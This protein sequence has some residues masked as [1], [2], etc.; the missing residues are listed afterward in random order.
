[1]LVGSPRSIFGVNLIQDVNTNTNNVQCHWLE[2]RI[3]SVIEEAGVHDGLTVMFHIGRF[4]GAS[5][6]QRMWSAIC[7]ADFLSRCYTIR[8]TK[9]YP[10]SSIFNAKSEADHTFTE[11]HP[12]KDWWDTVKEEYSNLQTSMKKKLVCYVTFRNTFLL[13]RKVLF[14]LARHCRSLSDNPRMV[15]PS[16]LCSQIDLL[17][18]IAGDLPRM[19]F[20]SPT[21]L[22][23]LVN[24]KTISL[25]RQGD[26]DALQKERTL[27]LS[28]RPR[29]PKRKKVQTSV[30]ESENDRFLGESLSSWPEFPMPEEPMPEESSIGSPFESLEEGASSLEPSPGEEAFEEA[31]EPSPGEEAFEPSPGDEDSSDVSSTLSDKSSEVSSTSDESSSTSSDE[32]LEDSVRDNNDNNDT[33]PKKRGGK[34][35]GDGARRQ[36]PRLGTTPNPVHLNEDAVITSPFLPLSP[37]KPGKL[38]LADH[39]SETAGVDVGGCMFDEE[40]KAFKAPLSDLPCVVVETFTDDSGEMVAGPVEYK[41]PDRTSGRYK[42]GAIGYLKGDAEKK[43]LS[44]VLCCPMSNASLYMFKWANYRTHF[45]CERS[46]AMAYINKVT[47]TTNLDVDLKNISTKQLQKPI[48]ILTDSSLTDGLHGGEKEDS[49]FIFV[50]DETQLFHKAFGSLE[51]FPF[52]TARWMR[53]FDSQQKQRGDSQLRGFEFGVFDCGFG[54]EGVSRTAHQTQ[55]EGLEYVV[56]KPYIF[57]DEEMMA[58]LGPLVDRCTLLMDSICFEGG[59]RMM[60]D[61]K[62]DSIFGEE[63]RSKTNSRFSRMEAYTIARQ[64]LC[65]VEEWLKKNTKFKGTSRHLGKTVQDSTEDLLSVLHSY[66]PNTDFSYNVDTRWSELQEARVQDDRCIQLLLHLGDNGL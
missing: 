49:D 26:V 12:D 27:V 60:N 59:T 22:D 43:H 1:M 8:K 44:Q 24:A 46:E 4:G 17:N 5:Y 41:C 65:T 6:I 55:D 14:H 45:T 11:F 20:E 35:H 31:L 40:A 30:T 47:T 7:V 54:R 28:C 25:A 9:N 50:S 10:M 51:K 3:Q 57:G 16:F 15:T 39:P 19:W 36:R 18:M 23:A 53:Y 34:F 42:I 61:S 38:R 37:P 21:Y 13:G 62:R 66:A 63:L 29:K 48:K 33:G 58:T 32:S 64:P 2:N 56:A 52:P